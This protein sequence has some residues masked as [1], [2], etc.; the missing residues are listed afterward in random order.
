MLGSDV[1]V[2]R[3]HQLLMNEG[4]AAASWRALRRARPFDRRSGSAGVGAI[5]AAED[6]HQ[7]A[8]PGAI[9]AHE[10]Q[11]FTCGER[12]RHVLQRQDSGEPFGDSS[13]E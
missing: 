9:F 12:Q 7:G 11:H 1:E 4:D 2:G 10:R 3:E 8:L 13:C 6:L 5:R